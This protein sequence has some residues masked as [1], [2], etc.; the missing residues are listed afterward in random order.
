MTTIESKLEVNN[1]SMLHTAIR[2]NALFCAASGLA[3]TFGSGWL[4]SLTGIQPPLA[5]T[6][7][8]I[9]LLGYALTLWRLASQERIPDGATWFV[10]SADVAWVVGS[11]L[12][13]VFGWLPLTLAGKWSVA[14]IADLVGLFAVWQYLGYRKMKT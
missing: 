8:G 13:L 12:V 9:I 5:L 7:T 4:A 10:I 6:I 14:I 2:G 3:L 11:I 1:S